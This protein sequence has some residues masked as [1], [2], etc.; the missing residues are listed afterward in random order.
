[1]VEAPIALANTIRQR[2]LEKQEADEAERIKKEKEKAEK[3]KKIKTEGLE[4]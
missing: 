1:M 2:L 4:I 3:I